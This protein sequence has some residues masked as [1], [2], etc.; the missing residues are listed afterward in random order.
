MCSGGQLVPIVHRDTDRVKGIKGR[1]ED[2]PGNPGVGP[3][4]ESIVLNNR[5]KGTETITTNN[6]C[7][8]D[9]YPNRLMTRFSSIKGGCEFDDKWYTG[10]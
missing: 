7:R 3:K 5:I 8:D 9:P 1:F 10:W 4:L 2:Q 6:N